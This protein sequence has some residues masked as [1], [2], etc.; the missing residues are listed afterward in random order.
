MRS[1]KGPTQPKINFLKKRNMPCGVMT[2]MSEKS[3]VNNTNK[4]NGM[5]GSQLY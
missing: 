1:N 5:T 2:V 4:N 3:K